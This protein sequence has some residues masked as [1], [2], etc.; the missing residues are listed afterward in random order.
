[1]VIIWDPV[2]KQYRSAAAGEVPAHDRQHSMLSLADHAPAEPANYNKLIGFNKDTGMVEAV[3]KSTLA[4]AIIIP[5]LQFASGRS[6][7]GEIN[8]LDVLR[9]WWDGTSDAW[10]NYAPE[11][12]FY[13]YTN[14][15]R[16]VYL[17]ENDV[18]FKRNK[19]WTHAP[20]LNGVKYPGSNLYAGRLKHPVASLQASGIHTEYPI[21]VP[22]EQNKQRILTLNPFE[23]IYNRDIGTGENTLLSAESY[24]DAP[25]DNIKFI[26]REGRSMVF[27]F[28]I[29][30]DVAGV[31]IQGPLSDPVYLIHQ[32]RPYN[33]AIKN[34]L[35]Y[36]KTAKQHKI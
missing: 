3:D 24:S 19:K 27:R 20:H 8:V 26:S 23:F 21:A 14:N 25:V 36:S 33:G 30:I 15:R 34:I 9:Y 1:M 10:L 31:K 6:H 7:Q 11:I 12:W 5:Q 16:K 29:V 35:S 2:L 17:S 22:F 28:A 18:I 13:R 32:R 4:S